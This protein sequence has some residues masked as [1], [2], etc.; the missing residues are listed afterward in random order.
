MEY[1]NNQV[2]LYGDIKMTKFTIDITWHN[3]NAFSYRLRRYFKYYK[4]L[5]FKKWQLVETKNY[6]TL[7]YCLEII[8]KE[9]SDCIIEIDTKGI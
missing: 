1:T 8:S 6:A 2:D 3:D 9:H 7:E 5:S 4:F